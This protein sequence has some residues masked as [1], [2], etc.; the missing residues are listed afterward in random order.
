MTRTIAFLSAIAICAM[1]PVYA[2]Y[3]VADKGT[4]PKS[5]PKELEPLRKQ[6]RTLEGPLVLFLHYEI[7]F[8]KRDQFESAWPYLLKVKS[9]G[10]PVILVRAPKTGFFQVKPGG[11]FIHSPPAGTANPEAPIDST[12][13]RERWMWTTYI[14]LV[15]DGKIVDLNRIP[16]PADT[17]IIDE[18]FKDEKK[19]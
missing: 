16:L 5:W 13:T 15:D 7:P 2:D 1:G 17:P 10:A 14:E 18:R 4:W 19:K 11:V 12:N 6:A 3:S 9:K 8:T